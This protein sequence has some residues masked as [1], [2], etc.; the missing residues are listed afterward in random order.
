MEGE[1]LEHVASVAS[2]LGAD[3]AIA[4]KDIMEGMRNSA[5]AAKELKLSYDE[6]AAIVTTVGDVT[7][8]SASTIDQSFKTMF[9]RMI[10]LKEGGPMATDEDGIG[11]GRIGT[12]L[13]E[14]GF[15]ALDQ[16][17]QLKSL[18]EIINELGGEWENLTD[19]ERMNVAQVVGGKRQYTD[20]LALMNNFDKYKGFLSSAINEDGSTLDTQTEIY[21]QSLEA[22]QARAQNSWRTAMQELVNPEVLKSL[23]KVSKAVGDMFGGITSGIGGIGGVMTILGDVMLQ[24]YMPQIQSSL[25]RFGE[26]VKGTFKEVQAF[27]V[28]FKNGAKGGKMAAGEDAAY[29]YRKGVNKREIEKDVAPQYE[30]IGGS[31]A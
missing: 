21:E 8:K 11:L 10:D 9:A 27:S 19:K 2:R 12:Q 26:S 4:F 25:T 14:L 30:Q 1:E 20:F 3:S 31:Q 18:S 29:E 15:S 28:G 23:A 16:E 7:Q 22:M 6:L 24:K 5:S 17:G 13:A